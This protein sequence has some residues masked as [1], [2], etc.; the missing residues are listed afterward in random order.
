[1]D[2]AIIREKKPILNARSWDYNA[3]EKKPPIF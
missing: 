3:Q 2:D 1:M